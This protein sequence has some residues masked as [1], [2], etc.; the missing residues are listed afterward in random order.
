MVDLVNSVLIL[1]SLVLNIS[2]LDGVQRLECWVS[3]ISCSASQLAAVFLAF[4][5]NSSSNGFAKREKKHSHLQRF[6]P[7]HASVSKTYLFFSV[8]VIRSIRKVFKHAVWA[9]DYIVGSLLCAL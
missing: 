5:G 1:T 3:C 4:L 6:L 8:L 2:V 7:G 9:A